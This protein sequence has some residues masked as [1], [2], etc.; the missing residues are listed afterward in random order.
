[1]GVKSLGGLQIDDPKKLKRPETPGIH[2]HWSL[3][4]EI[5]IIADMLFLSRQC[6][7]GTSHRNV[8][9]V[10]TSLSG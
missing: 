3:M 2:F 4:F 10:K 5:S 9:I 7:A 6:T 1:M 8:G